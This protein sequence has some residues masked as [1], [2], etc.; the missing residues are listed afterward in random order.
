[1]RNGATLANKVSSTF[2]VTRGIL[3]NGGTISGTSDR[4]SVAYQFNLPRDNV[5]TG[6]KYLE[7]ISTKPVF[8]P[9]ELKK[10][11]AITRGD[12]AKVTPEVR[13]VELLYSAA[14]RKGLGNSVLCAEHNLGKISSENFQQYVAENYKS[15]NAAVVGVGI[16]HNLLVAYAKSLNLDSGS[17]PE[18]PPST[19]CVGEKTVPAPGSSV[20]VAVGTSGAALSNQKEALAF[21]VLQQV[22]GVNI[23]AGNVAGALG[24]V[25]SSTLNGPF[26]FS[27]LNASYT[28]NGLFGFVLTAD[29]REAG[30]VKCRLTKEK[31]VQPI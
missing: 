28:D 10:A 22:A 6:L 14:F 20:S 11:E 4:E 15:N 17:L 24:K 23:S 3:F 12:L 19:F 27:A 29:G 9:W 18:C 5:E 7:D 26:S 31:T 2:G 8:K 30:K 1:M 21:A 13:A 16:D 25:V